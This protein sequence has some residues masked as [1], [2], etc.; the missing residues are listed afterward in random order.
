M[1]VVEV[2]KRCGVQVVGHSE[3]VVQ[4]VS[5]ENSRRF[6]EQLLLINLSFFSEASLMILILALVA[7]ALLLL[8]VLF[9]IIQSLA[10]SALFIYLSHR[11]LLLLPLF[12]W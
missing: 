7:A 2:K 6:R 9:I 11:L 1:T 12:P 8:I 5:P 10:L 4:T 3:D